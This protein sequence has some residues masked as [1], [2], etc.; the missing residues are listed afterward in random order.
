MWFTAWV[1]AGQPDLSPLKD[2]KISP[3]TEAELAEQEQQFQSDKIKG[4]SCD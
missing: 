1:N 3:E 4:R 2:K